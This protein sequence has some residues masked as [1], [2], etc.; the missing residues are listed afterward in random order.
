MRIWIDIASGTWGTSEVAHLEVTDGQ[1]ATI[2]DDLNDDMRSH[3]AELVYG[4]ESVADALR[5]VAGGES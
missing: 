1:L 4:G 3:L 5:R 2:S